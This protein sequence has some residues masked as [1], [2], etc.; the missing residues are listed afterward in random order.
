MQRK[1]IDIPSLGAEVDDAEL[2]DRRLNRR[3]GFLAEH[4]EG[5][6]GQ[7]F[8]KAQDDAGLEGAYRFSA[9]ER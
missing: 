7:S 4:L 9:R 1:R 3:L 2:G 5:C 8:P 6:P